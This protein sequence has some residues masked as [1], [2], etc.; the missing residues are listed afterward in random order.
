MNDNAPATHD[1]TTPDQSHGTDRIGDDVPVEF[2]E[3]CPDH[4]NTPDRDDRRLAAF[5]V[6]SN[7]EYGQACIK[8]TDALNDHAPFATQ[9]VHDAPGQYNYETI[10]THHVSGETRTQRLAQLPDQITTND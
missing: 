10:Q 5:W 8:C 2:C 3:F 4:P 9:V 1:D 7:R 6:K